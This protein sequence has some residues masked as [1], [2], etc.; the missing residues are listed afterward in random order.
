MF[1]EEMMKQWKYILPV[2]LIALACVPSVDLRMTLWAFLGIPFAATVGLPFP[3]HDKPWN[4]SPWGAIVMA[5]TWAVIMTLLIFVID[6]IRQW[7]NERDR[8]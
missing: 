7:Q 4:V 1:G 3:Y 8:R 2:C 6:R 5:V